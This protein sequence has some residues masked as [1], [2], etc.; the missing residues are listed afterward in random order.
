MTGHDIDMLVFQTSAES[1]YNE[2]SKELLGEIESAMNKCTKADRIA[3]AAKL[4]EI[5][6]PQDDL[7][8]DEPEKTPM[9]SLAETMIDA[10]ASWQSASEFSEEVERR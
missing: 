7:T 2:I 3:I 5:E 10:L 6:R 1:R 9:Q 4:C 8:G